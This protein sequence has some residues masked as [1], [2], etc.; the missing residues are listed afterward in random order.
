MKIL[1]SIIIISNLFS[2]TSHV[3]I[4]SHQIIDQMKNGNAVKYE[5]KVFIGNL[6]FTELYE[7]HNNFM[8]YV[9]LISLCCSYY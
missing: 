6:D 1:I 8:N 4:E 9:S 2:D 7:N 5:N 3:Q